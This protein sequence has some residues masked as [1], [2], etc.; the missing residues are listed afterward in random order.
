ME[1]SRLSQ[2]RRYVRSSLWVV[3]I[4]TMPLALVTSRILRS[5]DPWLGWHFLDLS[6]TGARATLELIVTAALSF[7]VFTFGSLLV[8]IQ[9]ASSQLTPRIIATT[10]L[11]D[12]VV[13][14]TVSLFIFTL[15]FALTAQNRIQSTVPEL[16][17]FVAALLGIACFAAFFYLIDYASR[18][19]RPISILRHV[20][21]S[22]LDV[23]RNVYPDLTPGA[24]R[25]EPSA[26]GRPKFVMVHQGTSGIVLTVNTDKLAAAAARLGG[27]IEVVPQMGDFVATDEPVFKLYGKAE[28][29]DKKAL[30]AMLDLGSERTMEQDPTFAFRIVVDIALRALS[31]A[32]NDPTTAVLAIDQLHRM[33]RSVGNRNLHTDEILDSSGR[34]L[35]IFRTPNWVDFVKLAFSEIRHFGS[36]QLQIVR[37]LRSM[38]ENLIDTLPAHRHV[39]LQQELD[40][41]D[42]DIEKNFTHNEDL[43]LARAADPQG[44]GGRAGA[45]G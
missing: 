27:V 16:V 39:A 13:K 20:A 33:L 25:S 6:P 35:V 3:P 2:V 5:I 32:I 43:A 41:I 45:R 40:L 28:S 15:L 21:E 22:G 36:D 11:R 38:T 7:V 19:L 14:Y 8:A 34:L 29:A 12:S 37:R 9:V 1:W 44:L 10:L 31:P 17:V 18:L 26:L 4:V 30:S 42:R 24:E 23:I